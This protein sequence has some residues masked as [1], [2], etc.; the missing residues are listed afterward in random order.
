M[1]GV[2]DSALAHR[3]IEGFGTGKAGHEK[4]ATL[5][6]LLPRRPT[7]I[8]LGFVDVPNQLPGYYLFNDFPPGLDV[9]GLLVRDDLS[10]GE[11]VPGTALH[12]TSDELASWSREGEAFVDAPSQGTVQG[13]R[14]VSFAQDSL[15]N[16]FTV[17]K[18]DRATGRLLS[19]LFALT[20]DRLRL[21]V[22]GGRDPVRLRVS[23]LIDGRTIFCATGTN[24]ET[25]GRREWDI[26]PYRG[27]KAAIEIVDDATGAWGHLL[28]DE[29]S[30]WR[31]RA[32][33]TGK[34]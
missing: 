14:Q 29:I 12:M 21:L 19:P 20:G 28:V 31:G 6:E 17:E 32:D 16:S 5:D 27:K 10:P 13:Q 7:Y 33:A 15:V 22:G 24:H 26:A 3:K 8:K 1:Y 4:R 2:V 30:Q 9:D 34:L 11:A 18:G 25:L 23:L